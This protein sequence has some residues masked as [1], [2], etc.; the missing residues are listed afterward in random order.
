V[1]PYLTVSDR[2][3]L[4]LPVL[5]NAAG[6]L[7][8]VSPQRLRLQYPAD[9]Q[10]RFLNEL[11]TSA[12]LDFTFSPS[13][14]LLDLAGVCGLTRPQPYVRELPGR[15]PFL[16]AHFIDEHLLGVGASTTSAPPAAAWPTTAPP[17]HDAHTA[18]LPTVCHPAANVVQSSMPPATSQVRQSLVTSSS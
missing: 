1:I 15:D 9:A 12:G 18:G 13:T 10:C 11:C 8:N 17:L 3:L 4:P 16:N 7:C 14:P 2:K 6:L 5:T